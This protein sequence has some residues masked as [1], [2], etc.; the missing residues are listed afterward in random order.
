MWILKK[1]GMVLTAVL[2]SFYFFPFEFSFLPGVNTKMAM[3]GFGLV[4]LAF[5][6]ARK[7][8][9]RIDWDFFKLS[10]WAGA[11]S[12]IGFIAVVW[13]DTHD[14]TYATYP[15]SYTHL[16]LPTNSLV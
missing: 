9:S 12:L 15:V 1:V 13:N 6:L 14:Y 7:Q 16:T 4:L 11:V 2:T 5:R 3:A 8:E 10:L